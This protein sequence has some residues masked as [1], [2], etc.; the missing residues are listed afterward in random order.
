[1]I[2]LS[3][4]FSLAIALVLS[5]GFA[6]AQKFSHEKGTATS[7]TIQHLP[8]QIKLTETSGNKIEIIAEGYEK[9][10][11]PEKAKGLKQINT[12]G[13]D[14]T[15][16]GLM[17][18]AHGDNVSFTGVEKPSGNVIYDFRVPKGMSVKIKNEIPWGSE[19][20]QV[21]DFSS[22][23]EIKTMNDDIRLNNVT[24]PLTIN[25]MNGNISILF[26]QVSQD[27]PITVTAFNG[28]IDITMPAQTPANLVLSSMNGNIYSD[29]GLEIEENE[30]DK[31]FDFVFVGGSNLTGTINKGGVEMILKAFNDNIY[32]RKN[33]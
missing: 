4:I 11:V 32:L 15:K 33:K 1:M 2:K 3:V 7:V 9:E 25:S 21:K 31:G 18:T 12:H 27:A 22:D 17:M 29:F 10:P 23:L 30:N 8:A 5:G 26:G 14:N 24:G 16:I 20:L 13:E 28:E 6:R 19:G